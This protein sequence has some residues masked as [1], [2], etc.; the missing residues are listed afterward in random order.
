VRWANDRSVGFQSPE[1]YALFEQLPEWVQNKLFES[2]VYKQFL[3]KFRIFFKFRKS[4]D[5]S[6][7][8]IKFI[9]KYEPD[10]GMAMTFR[11]YSVDSF[12]NWNDTQYRDFMR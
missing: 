12:F 6:T 5:E 7:K 1:D 3:E 9:N 10:A 4:D 8:P 11:D 2:Y